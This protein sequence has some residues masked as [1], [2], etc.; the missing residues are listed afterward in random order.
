MLHELLTIIVC[1]SFH[2]GGNEF[3]RSFVDLISFF[4]SQSGC[5]IISLHNSLSTRALQSLGHR[6]PLLENQPND[7]QIQRNNFPS[8]RAPDMLGGAPLALFFFW[9]PALV[10]ASS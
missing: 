5:G 10:I 9:A 6:A 8:R 7:G 3:F 1:R 4:E 2:S